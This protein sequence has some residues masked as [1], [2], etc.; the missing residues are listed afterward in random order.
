MLR[1]MC[2]LA[3]GLGI[4]LSGPAAAESLIWAPFPYVMRSDSPFFSLPFAWFEWEDFEGTTAKPGYS[5][6]TG[7]RILGPSALTDSVD[8]DDGILDGSGTAGHSW[9]SDGV[10]DTFTFTFSA[11]VLGTLPTHVGIV[12]TDVGTP[13]PSGGLLGVSGIQFDAFGPGSSPIG[14]VGGELGDGAVDGGTGEDRFFGVYN[15]DGVSS[16]RIVAVSS[17]DWEVDHLQYGFMNPV[18]EPEQ[19]LLSL[20]GLGVLAWRFRGAAKAG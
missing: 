15:P 13:K 18:P 3:A 10:T 5:A 16:I 4:G 2:C 12:F 7:G 17:N 8:A 11:A 14:G 9:F 20:L 19:W 6:T 1:A